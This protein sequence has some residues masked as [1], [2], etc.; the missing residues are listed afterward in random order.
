MALS[1]HARK[2]LQQRGIPEPFVDV[3]MDFGAAKHV[4][5]GAEIV[6]LRR[7]DQRIIEGLLGRT[8]LQNHY[9]NAYVMVGRDGCVVTAGHRYRRIKQH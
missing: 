4:G 5:G 8:A 7:K 2:R 6:Y 9:Q 3:I 1:N